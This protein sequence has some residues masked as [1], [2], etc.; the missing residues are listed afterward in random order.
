MSIRPVT[1]AI[2]VVATTAVHA[3]GTMPIVR[4]IPAGGAVNRV[5]VNRAAIPVR[6][7]RLRG[8]L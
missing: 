2:T 6:S 8:G 1:M 3:A 5:A 4:E 7:R